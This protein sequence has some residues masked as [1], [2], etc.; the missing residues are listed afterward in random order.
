MAGPLAF[1]DGQFRRQLAAGE[2]A[3]NPFET[4]ALPHLRGRVLDLGCGLG[5]LAL[6]AGRR[7]CQ[8]LAVDACASAVGRINRDAAAEGL[9]VRAVAA[10]LGDY[11]IEGEYDTV[12]CIGLLMF[13]PRPRALTLLEALQAAVA[14]GGC[15]I[16]NVLVEGTSYLEMFGD[17]EYTLFGRGEIAAR[18]AGWRPC[19]SRIEEFPAPRATRKV[20][21]TVIARKPAGASR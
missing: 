12:N 19:L 9:R 10:D 2:F 17:E 7:G 3:L 4:A 1:F 5:N 13:L 11:A 15:A 20:F 14:G 8:V 18:F 21:A 6:A 16:V